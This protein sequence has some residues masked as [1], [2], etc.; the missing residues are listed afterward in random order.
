[1][2]W[3]EWNGG[4]HLLFWRW[5]GIFWTYAWDGQPHLWVG[6]PL[7]YRCPQ[8][9]PKTPSD[10]QLVAHKVGKLRSKRYLEVGTLQSLVPYF[11]VPKGPRDIRVVF[12]GTSCH[13]NKYLFSLPT[14]SNLL[15][16]MEARM[17]QADSDY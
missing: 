11:Y 4:S 1:M 12:N 8:P 14:I 16:S 9:A 15:H 3:W 13:L 17:Y 7:P 10:A 2:T 5:P 6:E